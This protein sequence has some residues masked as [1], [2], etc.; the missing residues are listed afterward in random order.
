MKNAI[1][2][3]LTAIAVLVLTILIGGWI[4]VWLWGAIMV[5]VFGLPVLTIWQMWGLILLAHIIIPHST[6]T[7]TSSK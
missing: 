5:K 3:C 4:G 2:G 7:T 6:S 1:I